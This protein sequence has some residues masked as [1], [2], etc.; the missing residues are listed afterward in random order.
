MILSKLKL[1]IARYDAWCE[2]MGLTP[3][4]KRSCCVYKQDPVNEEKKPSNSTSLDA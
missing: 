1:W 4:H 2:E 3:K